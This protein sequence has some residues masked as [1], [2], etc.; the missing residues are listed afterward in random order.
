MLSFDAWEGLTGVFAGCQPWARLGWKN[1]ATMAT[2]LPEQKKITRHKMQKTALT[3]AV[4]L[5]GTAVQAQDVYLGVTVDYGMPKSGDSQAAASLLAGGSYDLG[6]AAIGAE[7]EYGA[8]AIFGGDYS[9]ARLRAIGSFDLGEFTGLASIGGTRFGADS[10]SYM[11]YNLGIGAQ[12]PISNALEV[13]GELIRDFMD[14]FGSDVI[15]TRVGAVY[16][17]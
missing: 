13:R 2:V 15:T 10:Q 5:L 17:F 9:T 7:A 11:G 14:D 16:S 3:L 1:N 4:A 12:F 8:A 6:L